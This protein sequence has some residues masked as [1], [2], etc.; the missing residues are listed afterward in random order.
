M[1]TIQPRISNSSLYL[2]IYLFIYLQLFLFSISVFCKCCITDMPLF[3][4]GPDFRPERIFPRNF[5]ARSF[6]NSH[7]KK[8]HSLFW[9]FLFII[10]LKIFWDKNAI[11]VN[12]IQVFGFAIIRM[13]FFFFAKNDQWSCTR[14]ISVKHHRIR[15][16]PLRRNEKFTRKDKKILR[17]K[18]LSRY[19]C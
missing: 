19:L 18:K 6:K 15:R 3:R 1:S 12:Y 9:F 7:L 2:F 8:K 11:C 4:P 5:P 13:K 17:G 14:M 16:S 10:I